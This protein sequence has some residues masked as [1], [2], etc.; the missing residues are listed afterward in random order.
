[1]SFIYSSIYRHVILITKDKK[2]ISLAETQ[3][4][5]ILL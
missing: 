1:M 5:I 4:V 2:L 3:K